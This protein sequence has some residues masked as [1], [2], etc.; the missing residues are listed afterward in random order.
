LNAAA[1]ASGREAEAR[2]GK[3][4]RRKVEENSLAVLDVR[5]LFVEVLLFKYLLSVWIWGRGLF[6]ELK[7]SS[8]LSSKLGIWSRTTES[9]DP[10]I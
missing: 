8:G 9:V 2:R 3:I 5:S 4:V 1:T 10:G 7:S 6:R